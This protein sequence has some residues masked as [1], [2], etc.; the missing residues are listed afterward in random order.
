MREYN[1]TGLKTHPG[2]H[3]VGDASLTRESH[4]LLQSFLFEDAKNGMTLN[5]ESRWGSNELMMRFDRLRQGKRVWYGKCIESD[6]L[7][8]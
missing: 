8:N 3:V 2:S 1:R 6:G 5:E 4:S 7:W